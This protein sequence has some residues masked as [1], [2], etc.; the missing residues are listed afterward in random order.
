MA[1]F[2]HS[3]RLSFV[4]SRT[5]GLAIVLLFVPAVV[6]GEPSRVSPVLRVPVT[7]ASPTGGAWAT[8]ERLEQSQQ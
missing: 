5:F 4:S 6:R 1:K 2:V 7:S 3:S 8:L